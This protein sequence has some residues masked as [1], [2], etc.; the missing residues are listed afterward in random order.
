MSPRSLSLRIHRLPRLIITIC[1][2]SIGVAA[3]GSDKP[4][5][6]SAAS[7]SVAE[8]ST[9]P[10][11][12]SL[13]TAQAST[14]ARI[15]LKNHEAGGA[16]FDGEVQFGTAATFQLKG[17]VDWTNAVGRIELTTKRNDNVEVPVQ[18]IVW[19]GSSVFLSA[20]GLTEALAAR[21]HPGIAFLQRPVSIR[22]NPL[23]QVITLIASFSSARAE[24]PVLLRQGDTSFEGVGTVRGRPVQKLRFG[25]STYSVADDGFAYQI[26]TRFVSIDGP[27]VIGFTDHG[28][29]TLEPLNPTAAL[30]L[31]Q[32]VDVYN[33]LVDS[34]PA[35]TTA[36]VS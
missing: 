35:S 20:P 28:L 10:K 27:I 5:A 19:G 24:N 12:P 21:G 33:S 3:C 34:A 11:G 32:Y 36:P 7:N 31:A 4:A 30:P 25:R 2:L 29:K 8:A 15:L 9:T 13:T 1:A 16:K 6:E 23:D 26:D 18:T 14:L 22:T 17:V